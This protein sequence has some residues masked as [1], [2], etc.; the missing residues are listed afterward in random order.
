MVRSTVQQWRMF[1]AVAEHGGFHQAA[2]VV[3]KSQSSIHHA[4]YKMENTLGVQLVSVENRKTSLTPAGEQLLQRIN[5]LLSEAERMESVALNYQAGGEP[6]INIAIDNAFPRDLLYKALAIVSQ[7]HPLVRIELMETVLSGADE[8]LSAGK[9]EIAV[10]P[11]MHH[12]H[13][14]EDICNITFVAV[15]AQSHPLNQLGRE[16][17]L[18]DLKSYR[19]IV[20]QDSGQKK[21][22]GQ[23][24]PGSMQR[25]VASN[26]TISIELLLNGFGFA[27]LPKHLVTPYVNSGQLS[28][29]ALPRCGCRSMMYYLNY[30]DAEKLG[31]VT[32]SFIEHLRHLITKD[33]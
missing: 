4:V 13:L 11:F 17:T 15:A 10:S 30:A 20:L 31:P 6:T 14:S 7:E 12:Y 32:R 26:I 23:G 27:W 1:K 33:I 24:W 3:F 25:W 16:V 9:A 21:I 28:P 8:L 5:F 18:E 29:L 19:Q 2:E 22:W